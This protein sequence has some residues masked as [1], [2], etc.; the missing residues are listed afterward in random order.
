MWDKIEPKSFQNRRYIKIIDFSYNGIKNISNEISDA[1]FKWLSENLDEGK[2]KSLLSKK[3]INN[4]LQIF[5]E[6]TIFAGKNLDINKV[7]G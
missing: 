3:E 6:T 2:K 7:L 5:K 1:L 4:E